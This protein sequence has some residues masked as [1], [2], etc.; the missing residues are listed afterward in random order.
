MDDACFRP[1]R[2]PIHQDGEREFPP[3]P[4]RIYVLNGKPVGACRS[5]PYI[6]PPEGVPDRM[7]YG[8]LIR[9][10]SSYRASAEERVT[11]RKRGAK[12][13]WGK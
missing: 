1:M 12:K 10:E 11:A 9:A 4:A 6:R 7:S 5:V 2:I 3:A 8:A 13:R